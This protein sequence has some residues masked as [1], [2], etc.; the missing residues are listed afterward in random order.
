MAYRREKAA[1]TLREARLMFDN[2]FWNA[3]ANRLYYACFYALTAAFLAKESKSPLT[4]AGVKA[5]FNR[6]FVQTGK[7]SVELGRFY[8]KLFNK[9]QDA[10]Y[11]DLILFTAEEIEPLLQE[12]ENFI[13]TIEALISE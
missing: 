1:E 2:G 7:V 5:K 6:D 8:N 13:K 9:R 10:D 12:A 3:T 4:H 11:K